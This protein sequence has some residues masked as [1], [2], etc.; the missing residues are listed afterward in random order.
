[1]RLI[2]AEVIKRQIGV[3]SWRR[4]GKLMDWYNVRFCV[5]DALPNEH[6]AQEFREVFRGKVGLKYD[7]TSRSSRLYT[8]DEKSGKLL[9]S[10]TQHFDGF[11][12][13]IKSGNWRMWGTRKSLDPVLADIVS[14]C[15][16]LKRDE[17]E[18]KTR[19]GG[20]ELMGVWRKTGPDDFAHAWAYCHLA[21]LVRPANRMQIT[22]VGDAK[23]YLEDSESVEMVES[24]VWPG[25]MEPRKKSKYTIS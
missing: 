2:H 13:S 25:L 10:R 14:H 24:A 21:C 19:A 12:D 6:N 4:L 3:D 5:H 17:E 18:R 16:N 11:L 8:F 1:M 20:T 9:L 15:G 7:S 23:K 22:L